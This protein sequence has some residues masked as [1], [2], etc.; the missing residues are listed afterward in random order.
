MIL[1]NNATQSPHRCAG[2]APSYYCQGIARR[3]MF[4]DN[5]DR[6]FY[7]LTGLA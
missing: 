4:D 7:L 6:D 1:A 2:S 3:K 5:A